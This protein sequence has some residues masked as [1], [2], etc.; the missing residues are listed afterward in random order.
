MKNI[1]DVECGEDEESEGYTLRLIGN[2]RSGKVGFE[3]AEPVF[4]VFF[5]VEGGALGGNTLGR[6]RA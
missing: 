4:N 5:F 6:H 2:V 1:K 3:A